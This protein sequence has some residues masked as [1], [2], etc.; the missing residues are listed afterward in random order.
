MRQVDAA[1]DVFER[2]RDA[3]GEKERFD[4]AEFRIGKFFFDRLEPDAEIVDA[5]SAEFFDLFRDREGQRRFDLLTDGFL[6]QADEFLASD[7]DES[8]GHMSV[9]HFP[10]DVS[11]R[12]RIPDIIREMDHDVF[13]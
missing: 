9:D 13:V 7:L 2:L 4:L 11:H 1:S 6:D 10:A 3:W 5:V 8:A 12:Q